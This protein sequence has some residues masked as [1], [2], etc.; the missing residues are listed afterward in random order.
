MK[1]LDEM[2]VLNA[3]LEVCQGYTHADIPDMEALGV[4]LYDLQCRYSA[5]YEQFIN[6]EQQ[7][8]GAV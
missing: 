4:V 2:Y 5:I 3:A 8:G 1:I 6:D 7:K